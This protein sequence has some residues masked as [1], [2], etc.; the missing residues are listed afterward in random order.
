MEA[1]KS[2][3]KVLVGIISGEIPLP[4]LQIPSS[5]CVLMWPFLCVCMERE[6]TL[7]GVSSSSYKDISPI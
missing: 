4:G 7:S 5:C 3:I 1:G 6:N 2:K